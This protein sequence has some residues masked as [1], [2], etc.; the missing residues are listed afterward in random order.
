M[1]L[2]NLGHRWSLTSAL[3][4]RQGGVVYLASGNNRERLRRKSLPEVRKVLFDPQ[5]YLAGLDATECE[6]TCARLAT[7]QYFGVE[8]LTDFESGRGLREWQQDVCAQ[9]GAIW[10]QRAPEEES[11]VESA[12]LDAVEF[13]AEIP[14]S[15]ILLPTPMVGEREDEA[16]TLA[17]WLDAGLRAADALDVG[18]DLLAT[19]AV[20]E[21]ILNDS[22]FADAGLLDTIV[23]HV[24]ARDEIQ[25]AYVVIVQA[26]SRHPFNTPDIVLRA[27]LHLCRGFSGVGLETVLANF[28][29]VFGLPCMAAGAS[30]FCAGGSHA[31]RR[32]SLPGFKPTRGG[33]ALPHFYSHRTAAEYLSERDLGH[34]VQRKLLRRVRDTTPFSRAL[35]QRLEQGGSAADLPNWAESQNN[36]AQ[37]HKHLVNRLLREERRLDQVPAGEREDEVLDWLD[38]ATGSAVRVQRQLEGTDHKIA[39]APVGAWADLLSE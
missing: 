4:E 17:Q 5:L 31:Q 9:V 19:V 14:C 30:G 1:F 10:P 33:V 23:D 24:T 16:V 8:G 27:Y 18:Q 22:V 3:E 28:V 26:E 25:G 36:L 38:S 7:H 20:S 35:M 6:T 39:F 12:C 2:L 13:Q 34:V 29:G 11:A 37:A 32:L 21:A 15:H